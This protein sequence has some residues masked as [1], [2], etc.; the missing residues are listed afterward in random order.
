MTDEQ[1]DTIALIDGAH[2]AVKDYLRE[3]ILLQMAL[4]GHGAPDFD[5]AACTE[6][7]HR[8]LKT[9]GDRQRD[10]YAES[11]PSDTWFT[12]ANLANSDKR[13]IDPLVVVNGCEASNYHAAV[14]AAVTRAAIAILSAYEGPDYGRNYEEL[15]VAAQKASENALEW[16]SLQARMIMEAERACEIA[17][18]EEATRMLPAA[19]DGEKTN[20][21][22]VDDG[23]PVASPASIDCEDT[24]P[25]NDDDHGSDR[26][27]DS[28]GLGGAN[29]PDERGSGLF[30]PSELAKQ[31]GLNQDALRKRLERWR[32]KNTAGDGWVEDTGRTSREP[33]FLYKLSAIQHIISEM[34]GSDP[35]SERP[36][37]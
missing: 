28:E 13:G 18:A 24:A 33:R 37:K 12:R 21:V 5:R 10:V 16:D 22:A 19:P 1:C 9:L 31:Y 2:E 15:G 36:A 34:G 6:E 23:V 32:A 29:S 27:V 25:S 3:A 35:S 11:S 26:H 4:R 14:F 7:V 20:A 30:P 17:K 8:R